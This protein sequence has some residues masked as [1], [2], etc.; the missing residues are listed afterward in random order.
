MDAQGIIAKFDIYEYLYERYD[1]MATLELE[2]QILS[3]DDII[4]IGN[5]LYIEEDNIDK[6]NK[7]NIVLNILEMIDT[8]DIHKWENYIYNNCRAYD[9]EKYLEDSINDYDHE[10]E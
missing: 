1:W 10:L 3:E 9:L 2:K 5:Q 8:K 4:E 6:N 7:I